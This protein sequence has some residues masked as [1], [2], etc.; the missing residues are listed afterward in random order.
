M[1]GEGNS[2]IASVPAGRH[3]DIERAGLVAA[4]EQSADAV[5][6]CDTHG[7]IRYVN[8]AFTAMTG[9][10]SEEAAGRNPR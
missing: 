8:P 3:A 5:V 2:E 1:L 7:K 10:S 4:V 6:V 9:Y